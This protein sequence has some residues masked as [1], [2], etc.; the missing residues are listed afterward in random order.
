MKPDVFLKVIRDAGI[1][2]ISGPLRAAER[3]RWKHRHPGIKLPNEYLG[4]LKKANG[5]RF[6]LDPKSTIGAAGRLLPL[7]EI[8][9]ATELLYQDQEDEDQALPEAWLGLTDDAQGEQFLILDVRKRLYLGVD[10]EDPDEPERLGAELEVAL[11]WL[12][13]RYVSG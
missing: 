3:S 1:H 6:S 8:R 2:E 7:R 4:L 5:L 11:D 9:S 10:P 12:Y 13:A